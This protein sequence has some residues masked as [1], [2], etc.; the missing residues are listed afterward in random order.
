[1]KTYDSLSREFHELMSSNPLRLAG[2]ENFTYADELP[3]ISRLA[4]ENEAA[5]ALRTADRIRDAGYPGDTFGQQ[6]DMQ[7]AESWLTAHALETIATV[8]DTPR[9][10]VRPSALYDLLE[11]T[12]YFLERDTRGPEKMLMSFTCRME[13]LGKYLKQ[14]ISRL[15]MPVAPWVQIEIETAEGFPY[16]LEEARARAEQAN[17]SPA[18]KS[19]LEAA[20]ENADREVKSYIDKLKGL[21]TRSEMHIDESTVAQM[22]AYK[23]V[24]L[25]LHQM[26]ELAKTSLAQTRERLNHLRAA[27]T[28]KYGLANDTPILDV[29]EYLKNCFALAQGTVI[30]RVAEK[31]REAERFT[32]ESGFLRRLE[33]DQ[34]EV[35]STP[36]YLRPGVPIAAMSGPGGFSSNDLT[37]SV[38][39]VTEFSGIEKALN[40]LTMHSIT[41]H[42]LVPGHHYQLSRAA[43]HP[44]V[45]RRWVAPNNLI[46]GW[47]TRVAEQIFP[48]WGYRGDTNLENEYEFMGLI[49]QL[50]FGGRVCFVLFCL[51]G[52]RD[53]LGGTGV[54]ISND[55][56]INAATQL[57][58]GVTGF[59]EPRARGDVT[60]FSYVGTYGALYLVGNSEL[61][62]LEYRTKA[63]QG[64]NFTVPDFLE[65]VVSEGNMPPSYIA[66]ALEQKGTI[67]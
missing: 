63:K 3:D 7:L 35:R 38:Y 14:E 62:E 8:G 45:I 2:Q 9:H 22:F 28:G 5:E 33:N 61:R 44:S 59:E 37:R 43:K 57:Y 29:A 66:R 26:H 11:I 54:E 32:Y 13:G 16:M 25:S 48:E 4:K 27:L 34:A 55:G 50:R 30:G 6:L 56:P 21:P 60:L 42:E 23:G 40:S 49:D 31:F 19:R 1:M 39:Y 58:R 67:Q 51:T 53:Y 17:L 65:A 64:S 20:I 41:A 24:E 36:P 12:P 46:E 15:N 18:E 10:A 47:T 52:N